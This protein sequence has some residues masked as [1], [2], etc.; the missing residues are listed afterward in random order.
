LE[1]FPSQGDNWSREFLH[2]RLKLERFMQYPEL[3]VLL[4][5]FC[6]VSLPRPNISSPLLKISSPF[7]EH[8]SLW[9][10]ILWP[11]FTFYFVF[12]ICDCLSN[13]LY[14]SCKQ[15]DLEH[16]QST[17]FHIVPNSLLH[18]DMTNRFW[19]WYYHHHWYNYVQPVVWRC[20]LDWLVPP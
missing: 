19:F 3:Q 7:L 6:F 12:Y 8:I 14:I 17:L 13:P 16:K 2:S 4:V 5:L 1:R 10:Y 20:C 9:W 18:T 11:S 15:R